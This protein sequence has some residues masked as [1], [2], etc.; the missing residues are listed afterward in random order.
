M[1]KVLD[2]DEYTIAWV[3]VL[4]IEAGAALCMLEKQRMEKVP[5]DEATGSHEGR[6]CGDLQIQI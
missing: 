2:F 6:R 5:V 4:P 3:A 1:S